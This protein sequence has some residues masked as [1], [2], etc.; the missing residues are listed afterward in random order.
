[1]VNQQGDNLILNT[2]ANDSM[3]SPELVNNEFQFF[4]TVW[5]SDLF[6]KPG[7]K[8]APAGCLLLTFILTLALDFTLL[9]N[10]TGDFS[11]AMR[12]I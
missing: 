9:R 5:S 2:Q 8:T 11:P 6:A 12:E 4:P 3:T 1:M 10:L 7:H